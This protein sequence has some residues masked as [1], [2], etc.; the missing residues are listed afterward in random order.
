VSEPSSQSLRMRSR[1]WTRFDPL[2]TRAEEMQR[3]TL[4]APPPFWR[5]SRIQSPVEFDSTQAAAV[6]NW[7]SVEESPED[8][9]EPSNC[10]MRM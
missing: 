9:S 10:P 7:T 8:E 1:I 4:M 2:G 6:W 5:R 3:A